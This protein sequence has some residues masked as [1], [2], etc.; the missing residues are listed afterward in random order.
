MAKTAE[1][2]N[3]ETE[4]KYG[5]CTPNKC[6]SSEIIKDND[7]LQCRKCER[8]VH[9]ACTELPAYQIQLCLQYRSRNFQCNQCVTVTPILLERVKTS[10]ERV[11]INKATN[12][13][14]TN[15]E[16]QGFHARLDR[17][18]EKSEKIINRED[19]ARE[20]KQVTYAD[21][22]KKQLEKQEV[23][24]KDF[25]KSERD[26]ERWLNS[27]KCNII[28]HNMGENKDENKDE[29]RKGDKDYVDETVSLRMGLKVNIISAERIGARTDEMFK[30]KRWRPLK[31][32]L[33]NEEEKNQIMSSVHKLGRWDFR[34]TDDFSKKER[35]TIKEWHRKAER[36][37]KY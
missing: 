25:I 26:E 5:L 13:D 32:T 9:Y 10:K 8:K 27:T 37:E 36:E 17:L 31:V 15:E 20:H 1:K 2:T 6:F 19:V 21:T 24:I 3:T 33:K 14:N 30:T 18:E 11:R 22:T 4:Q 23:T 35:E 29:Q 12:T 34:V 16:Q 7:V 28:V